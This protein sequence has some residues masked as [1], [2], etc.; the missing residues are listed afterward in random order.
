MYVTWCHDDV[1][2]ARTHSLADG[3]I[4]LLDVAAQRLVLLLPLLEE[5]LHLG[6]RQR[7]LL[8]HALALNLQAAQRQQ[9]K[10]SIWRQS[11]GQHIRVLQLTVEQYTINCH[12]L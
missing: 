12:S 10:Y 6:Q 11:Q 3:A 9:H 8:H 7:A 4:E 5:R 2:H 1:T